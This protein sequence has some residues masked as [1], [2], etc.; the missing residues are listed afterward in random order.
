MSVFIQM[1]GQTP[2]QRADT[3]DKLLEQINSSIDS[4]DAEIEANQGEYVRKLINLKTTDKNDENDWGLTFQEL[5]I[6][7]TR[8]E[9]QVWVAV[10]KHN[11]ALTEPFRQKYREVA[12][13][14]LEHMEEGVAKGWFTEDNYISMAGNLKTGMTDTEKVSVLLKMWYAVIP[15]DPQ[16]L[17]AVGFRLW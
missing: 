8:C 3:A 11:W 9:K 4:C 10:K 12:D 13:Q 14:I 15:V 17:K 16:K 7:V 6:K 2:D 5:L 1:F